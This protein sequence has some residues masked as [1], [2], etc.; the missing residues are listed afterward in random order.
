[1]V[2]ACPN[3]IPFAGLSQPGIWFLGVGISGFTAGTSWDWVWEA[4][5]GVSCISVPGGALAADIYGGDTNGFA[6]YGG[7]QSSG[8]PWWFSVNP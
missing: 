3:G 4:Q 1:M 5:T 2:G 8:R 7:T 6:L